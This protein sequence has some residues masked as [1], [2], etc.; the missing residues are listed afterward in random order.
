MLYT[1]Q[2]YGEPLM[3]LRAQLLEKQKGYKYIIN[4]YLYP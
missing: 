1:I 3:C 2:M 4:K